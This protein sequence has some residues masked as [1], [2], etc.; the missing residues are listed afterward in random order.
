M[1]RSEGNNAFLMGHEERAMFNQY[2]YS[3]KTIGALVQV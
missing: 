1:A 3:N 2:W